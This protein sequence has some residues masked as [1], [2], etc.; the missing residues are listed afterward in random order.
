MYGLKMLQ[1][2]HIFGQYKFY[3][4]PYTDFINGGCLCK[5]FYS[6]TLLFISQSI[7]AVLSSKVF[8]YDEFHKSCLQTT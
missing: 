1:L 7:K 6:F 3:S 8:L 5:T 4:R 2:L